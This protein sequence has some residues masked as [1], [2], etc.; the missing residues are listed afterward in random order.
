MCPPMEGGKKKRGLSDKMKKR[1]EKVK[2]LMAE[3]G[4]SMIDAS[5]AI[6]SEKI[7]Y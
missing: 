7:E 3:R 1:M 2:Q 6:K 5:K 4:I